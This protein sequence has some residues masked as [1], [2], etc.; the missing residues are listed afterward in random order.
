MARKISSHD[1]CMIILSLLIMNGPIFEIINGP[2]FK[3]AV[4]LI[5]ALVG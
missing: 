3:S 5:L 1:I 2:D 4:Y